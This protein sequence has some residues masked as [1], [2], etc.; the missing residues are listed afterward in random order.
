MSFQ[1]H[2]FYFLHAITVFF[3]QKKAIES[4]IQ[5]RFERIDDV[6]F[7][8]GGENTLVVKV[9]EREPVGVW[10][11]SVER[12]GCYFI[13]ETS[14]IFSPAPMF[15]GNLFYTY[16]GGIGSRAIGS[17]FFSTSEF[18]RIRDFI[19]NLYEL[20]VET[21][22]YH[23]VDDESHEVRIK[24]SGTIIFEVS[25]P[26]EIILENIRAILASD[27]FQPDVQETLLEIDYIDLR[28]GNKVFFRLK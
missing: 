8:L 16:V 26:Y 2:T 9:H 27:A 24:R 4:A 6:V 5:T 28:F 20:G 13:D 7:Q 14:F 19:K 1:G 15:S 21:D 25:E 3:Y 17:T 23:V 12:D 22:T 10:C 18:A 11:E